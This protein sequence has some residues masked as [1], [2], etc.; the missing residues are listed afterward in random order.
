M[1]RRLPIQHGQRRMERTKNTDKN[2]LRVS[3]LGKLFCLPMTIREVTR[4]RW[5]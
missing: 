4:L 2:R 5:N 1:D 3:Q